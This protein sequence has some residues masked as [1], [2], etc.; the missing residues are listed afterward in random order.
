VSFGE[1]LKQ[2]REKANIK[3]S[4]LAQY[5]DTTNTTISNWE[6]GISKPYADTLAELC[7]V[8]DI[9]ANWLLGWK[10]PKLISL[11]PYE[12]THLEKYRA[13]DDHGQG[14]VDMVL[15]REY[16]RCTGG[17]V[18]NLDALRAFKNEQAAIWNDPVIIYKTKY[19]TA[20]SAGAGNPLED[21]VATRMPI[22]DTPL[23]RQADFLLQITGNSM[24][25]DYMHGDTLLVKST[26]ILGENDLGIF[27]LNG[28]S[29]F[30]KY[31]VDTLISLNPEVDDVE[32]REGDELK[33]VGKVLG[34]MEER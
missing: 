30:K 26:P 9:D 16:E 33:A 7:K 21:V 19:G 25:P 11:A 2:A 29:Y 17:K 27:I 22:P 12:R 15:D 20:A 13:L 23:N 31:G 34:K 5:L 3:Q 8:L 14:T 28:E 1:R 6:K 32:L 24:E 10:S 4:Q 18:V